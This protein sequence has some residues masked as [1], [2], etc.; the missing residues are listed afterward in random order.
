MKFTTELRAIDPLDG[1]LKTWCGPYINAISFSDA[2][3]YC[4]NNGLGYLVVTGVL[5]AEVESDGTIIN[6]NSNEN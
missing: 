1:E 6:H 3:Q 2:R 4:D 5:V